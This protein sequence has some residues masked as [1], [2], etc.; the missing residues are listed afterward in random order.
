MEKIQKCLDDLIV[1]IKEGNS[2]QTYM[3]CEEKLKGQPELRGKIDEFRVAVYRFNN[4]D[5]GDDIF[6]KIDAFE[7]KYQD[8]KKNPLVNEY[9]EA[10]LD[11]C[12]L[13]QK[14]TDTIQSSA[15]IH[16]PRV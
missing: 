16:I 3:K 5:T 1:S 8:I 13:L 2:Y 4:E 15:E 10:E 11:V 7:E 14:V 6:E 9:L 12:R